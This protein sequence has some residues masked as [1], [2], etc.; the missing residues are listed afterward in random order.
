V[1][2]DFQEGEGET[3]G[4]REESERGKNREKK[5]RI[6]AAEFIFHS[7]FQNAVFFLTD[8]CLFTHTDKRL[9][10]HSFRLTWKQFC[11]ISVYWVL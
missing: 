9:P 5:K 1:A 7:I 4:E 6:I 8:Q 10:S 11:M 2:G 3:G